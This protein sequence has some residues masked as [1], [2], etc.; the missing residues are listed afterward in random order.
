MHSPDHA[1]LSF[2]LPFQSGFCDW[3]R[4][5]LILFIK[6]Y[7]EGDVQTPSE[8]THVLFFKSSSENII[9]YVTYWNKLSF[10][11]LADTLQEIICFI[12]L[13]NTTK[14]NILITIHDQLSHL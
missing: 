10:Q 11:D 5:R 8:V 14:A 13:I 9:L 2:V 12:L 1:F 3:R 4:P 7:L 6:S